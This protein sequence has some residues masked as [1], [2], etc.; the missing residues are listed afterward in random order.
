MKRSIHIVGIVAA[1][2]LLAAVGCKKNAKTNTNTNVNQAPVVNISTANVNTTA[3][4]NTNQ[5]P[6]QT[7]EQE[8]QRLALSFTE[9]YGSYSNQSNYANLEN[10]LVFMTNGFAD[11]TRQYVAEQR[12]KN[13]DT[14]V[15]YGI[16]AKAITAQTKNFSDAQGKAS[17]LVQTLRRES[18]GSTTNNKSY[19]QNILLN[20]EKEDGVWKVSD[21][22]WQ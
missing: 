12:K 14:S 3:S 16:T 9:R 18:I 5:A 22:K 7:Q 4:I 19:Q 1:V 15:Y 17:F 2:F 13:A 10:L 21:A 11:S 20:M 6:K 8:L